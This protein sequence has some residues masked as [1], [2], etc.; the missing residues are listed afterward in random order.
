MNLRRLGRLLLEHLLPYYVL[1]S[2]PER[3]R[4]WGGVAASSKRQTAGRSIH[5]SRRYSLLC[6]F[7]DIRCL[8]FVGSTPPRRDLGHSECDRNLGGTDGTYPEEMT[9]TAKG[10]GQTPRG[11]TDVVSP[12]NDETIRRY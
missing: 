11:Y 10:K 12:G 3:K 1:V 2:T 9:L 8:S 7:A 4:Y 6:G 5:Y